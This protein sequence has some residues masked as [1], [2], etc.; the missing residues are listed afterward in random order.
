MDVIYKKQ[1]WKVLPHLPFTP[2][3]IRNILLERN[4]EQVITNIKEIKKISNKDI[5]K[6]VKNKQK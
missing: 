1:R 4:G 6:F 5:L 2:G 3:C